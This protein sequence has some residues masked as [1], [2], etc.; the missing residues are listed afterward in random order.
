MFISPICSHLW[1][2]VGCNATLAT[3]LKDSASTLEQLSMGSSEE[4]TR[5]LAFLL[6]EQVQFANKILVNKTDLVSPNE[7]KKVESLLRHL[8]PS[9]EIERTQNSVRTQYSLESNARAQ[10]RSR[11]L[12]GPSQLHYAGGSGCTRTRLM[13]AVVMTSLANIGG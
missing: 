13:L 10:R 1:I 11:K 12:G 9:A 4:D 2:G 5:P 8:N 6:A 7:T 3:W